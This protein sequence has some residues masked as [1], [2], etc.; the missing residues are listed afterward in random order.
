[1]KK[2]TNQRIKLQRDESVEEKAFVRYEYEFYP[3]EDFDREEAIQSE[4]EQCGT[5]LAA[6]AREGYEKFGPGF[7]YIE[8]KCFSGELE[9]NDKLIDGIAEYIPKDKDGKSGIGLYDEGLY[10]QYAPE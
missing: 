7:I 9:W 8:A 4:L 5:S 3:Y 6:L 10:E 1:M 2:N